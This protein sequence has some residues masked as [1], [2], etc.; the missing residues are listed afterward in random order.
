MPNITEREIEKANRFPIRFCFFL[1]C[2]LENL[3]SNIPKRKQKNTTTKCC[4]VKGI[5]SV[6][7]DRKKSF[8]Y[9]N[10]FLQDIKKTS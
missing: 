10:L 1:D 3:I 5:K 9:K 6:F 8:N 2:F 7:S 4:S